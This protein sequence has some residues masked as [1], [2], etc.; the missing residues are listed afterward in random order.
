MIDLLRQEAG[1]GKSLFINS[2]N[3]TKRT[4]KND[5]EVKRE[6][7]KTALKSYEI[8][9]TEIFAPGAQELIY[10][11]Q[12]M[13]S[14]KENAP[15]STIL[16][17][18]LD[19]PPIPGIE[20][21]KVFTVNNKKVLVTAIIDPNLEKKA[22]HGL[23]TKDPLTALDEILKTPHDLA[24]AVLQFSD[25][26]A[27]QLIR[28]IAGLDIA[29]L[30]T[31]RGTIPK[32]ELING[33]W[34]V[35]N[36]NQ[37]KTIGYLDWNF[38]TGAPATTKLIKVDKETYE[39]DQKIVNLVRDYEA[40]LRQHYFEMEKS[41]EKTATDLPAKV[42]YVGSQACATCHPKITASWQNTKHARAYACLEKKCKDFCPDCL[43]CHVTGSS[44]HGK[45]GFRSPT[46]TPN[47]FNIQCEE[48]HGPAEE[49]LKNTNLP[50]GLKINVSTCTI[51]HTAHTDPEFSFEDDLKLIAH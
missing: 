27:R 1:T 24:I 12:I 19:G 20:T 29:I 40:W 5:F 11:R 39:A 31:Q 32:S 33:C 21:H 16:C 26:K 42:P 47:L 43:L 50:Y 6:V 48:C 37:G 9:G 45:Q 46:T 8:I 36:N 7:I 28:R 35:K 18:N 38:T 34:L 44:E 17:G 30:G 10:G 22:I 14:L 2:G 3:L 15:Q 41:K 13:S 51:C 49:H 23:Q 25:T 4:T